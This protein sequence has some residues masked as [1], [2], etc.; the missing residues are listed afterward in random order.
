MNKIKKNDFN[1][2][3]QNKSI[4]LKYNLLVYQI[5]SNKISINLNNYNPKKNDHLICELFDKEFSGSVKMK[6][7]DEKI[8]T[9][10]LDNLILIGIE[11][12]RDRLLHFNYMQKILNNYLLDIYNFDIS[13]CSKPRLKMINHSK[14]LFRLSTKYR[15]LSSFDIVLDNLGTLYIYDPESKNIIDTT[16]FTDIRKFQSNIEFITYKRS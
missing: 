4:L 9:T 15:G 16:I 12:K 11:L 14:N 5:E 3:L 13:K 8:F 1:F 7:S 10:F 2:I 6:K